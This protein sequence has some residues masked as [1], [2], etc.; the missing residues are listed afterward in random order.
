MVLHVFANKYYVS[1]S[2][3][4]FCRR[5]HKRPFSSFSYSKTLKICC[6]Q[7][8]CRFLSIPDLG[9]HAPPFSML[10]QRLCVTNRNRQDA[11][12]NYLDIRNCDLK[13]CLSY[14]KILLVTGKGR[15]LVLDE[16]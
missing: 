8:I 15:Y 16:P 10:F 2:F 1:F 4:H 7:H 12:K 14:Y 11:S 6:R 9:D 5:Y 13:N 3:M